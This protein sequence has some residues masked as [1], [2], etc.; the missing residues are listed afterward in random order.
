M[1]EIYRLI[2]KSR[3]N[4]TDEALMAELA[5]GN[6]EQLGELYQRYGEIV[7]RF[8]CRLLVNEPIEQA[9]DLCQE[10]FLAVAESAPKYR[11]KGKL[12]SW[13]LSIAA[14][15]TRSW[16]RRNWLLGRILKRGKN[17]AL[18][19]AVPVEGGPESSAARR[20]EIELAMLKLTPSQREVVVLRTTQ[21]MSGEEIA[22][23]LGISENAVW[24][25]LKRAHEILSGSIRGHGKSPTGEAI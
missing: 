9:E 5:R 25:R 13:I 24:L 14:R 22:K 20:Q 12:I 10:V 2:R 17:T 1:G 8:I 15:T 11:E 18:A 6:T 4:A 23:T 16:Q 19:V 7:F 21:G 3:H